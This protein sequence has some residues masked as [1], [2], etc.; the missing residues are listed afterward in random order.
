M[1]SD[2]LFNEENLSAVIMRNFSARQRLHV[3]EFPLQDAALWI[4][5]Q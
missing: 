2:R 4:V 3:L 5:D 1:S